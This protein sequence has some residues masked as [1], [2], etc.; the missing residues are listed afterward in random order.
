MFSKKSSVYFGRSF[1]MFHTPGP[2]ASAAATRPQ[3]HHETA[4]EVH[5][6]L[7]AEHH[8]GFARK[9]GSGP[10]LVA[11]SALRDPPFGAAAA[12]PHPIG[13]WTGYRPDRPHSSGLRADPSGDTP[14]SL[15]PCERH[16]GRTVRAA[17]RSTPLE[18]KGHIARARWHKDWAAAPSLPTPPQRS[19]QE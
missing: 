17:A 8:R 4:S 11:P 5:A 19:L 1:V 18:Y 12:I 9:L 16:P 15:R 13:R 14:D 2:C 7:L 10:L 3:K 6:G